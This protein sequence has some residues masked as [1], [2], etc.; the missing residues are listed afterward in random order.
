M[1]LRTLQFDLMVQGKFKRATRGVVF[2]GA[3]TSAP[4]SLGIVARSVCQVLLK[5]LSSMNRLMHWSFGSFKTDESAHITF[6][7]QM[8]TDRLLVT[9]PRE[10]PPPMTAGSMFPLTHV[11]SHS[12]DKSKTGA[13]FCFQP[14]YTYS[15]SFFSQNLALAQ[16]KI[17]NVPGLRD[18][19][20]R[21]FWGERSVLLVAYE[22]ED[23]SGESVWQQFN[24]ARFCQ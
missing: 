17:V 18:M 24:H 20:C 14:G 15:I 11:G 19:M 1:H 6:P 3:E 4:M 10:T 9:P 2:M 5:V 23:T 22:L 16:W 21:T 12:V 8:A 13:F 7:L